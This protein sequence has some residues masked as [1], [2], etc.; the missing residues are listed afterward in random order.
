M[1][2]SCRDG[3]EIGRWSWI[4]AVDA[5]IV[6]Q[7]VDDDH[8]R[9]LQRLERA[10]GA[11]FRRREVEHRVRHG[12][13]AWDPA[14]AVPSQR[15]LRR[16]LVLPA[17]LWREYPDVTVHRSGGLGDI[18]MAAK[19]LEPLHRMVVRLD[20]VGVA[21]IALKVHCASTLLRAGP[22]PADAAALAVEGHHPNEMTLVHLLR[23][24][25]RVDTGI[26]HVGD[27]DG[28]AAWA[29]APPVR[30]SNAHRASP[31]NSV[32]ARWSALHHVAP[33]THHGVHDD[34]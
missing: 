1:T 6:A 27:G 9:P 24:S 4:S 8:G 21:E 5:P 7:V 12:N 25:R 17:W 32:P 18:V 31:A 15:G 14:L 28:P 13:Q 20:R 29:V 19:Q 3:G 34:I 10:S 2:G 33:A 30:A 26:D 23:G 22:F 16:E 11:R